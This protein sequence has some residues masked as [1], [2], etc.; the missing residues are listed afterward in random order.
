MSGCVVFGY[1]ARP[2]RKVNGG[3][4][5]REFSSLLVDREVVDLNQS[6]YNKQS[7]HNQARQVERKGRTVIVGGVSDGITA[8]AWEVAVV[9]GRTGPV[10][11]D[12]DID[13]N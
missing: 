7:T 9:V 8:G 1:G 11:T 6:R 13:D 2:S 4:S 12:G 10:A 3:R 5:T